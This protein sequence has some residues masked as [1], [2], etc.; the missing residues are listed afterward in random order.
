MMLAVDMRL[1]TNHP[2]K[3]ENYSKSFGNS[4]GNENQT[5]FLKSINLASAHVGCETMRYILL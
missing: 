3:V 1:F 5:D 2:R 4:R